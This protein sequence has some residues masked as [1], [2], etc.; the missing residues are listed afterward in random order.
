M[1]WRDEPA[2]AQT[3]GVSEQK[4]LT[5]FSLLS[6]TTLILPV[7]VLCILQALFLPESE[8]TVEHRE[9]PCALCC[10]S[11]LL[12]HGQPMEQSHTTSAIRWWAGIQASARSGKVNSPVTCGGERGNG[13]K[14]LFVTA[15]DLP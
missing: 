11:I 5:E 10:L 14:L 13:Q 2:V 7:P 6:L 3:A 8:N 1:S 9:T 4:G 12:S 15:W